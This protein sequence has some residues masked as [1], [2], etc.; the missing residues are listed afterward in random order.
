MMKVT[1]VEAPYTAKTT[2]APPARTE[3]GATADT[4]R[5]AM[6]RI[7]SLF[8]A[9]APRAPASAG[10]GPLVDGAASEVLTFFLLCS[11]PMRP[12][13]D[14]GRAQCCAARPVGALAHN[15][16]DRGLT[17]HGRRGA[18]PAELWGRMHGR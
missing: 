12:C 18:V 8:R 14:R 17:G 16:R 3:I 2:G 5:D 9:S 6:A 4:T 7:P 13:C 11:G 1:G 15:R 10:A